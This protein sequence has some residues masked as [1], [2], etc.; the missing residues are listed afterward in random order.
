MSFFPFMDIAFGVMLAT[1]S[2][3]LAWEIPGIVEP[4]RLQSMVCKR[5]RHD[6]VTEQQQLKNLT[7]DLRSCQ[8]FLSDLLEV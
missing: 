4:G 7:P 3:I 8:L 2:N 5:V 6:L 1:H